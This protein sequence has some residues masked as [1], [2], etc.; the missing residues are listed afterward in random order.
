MRNLPFILFLLCPSLLSRASPVTR[1]IEL[2]ENFQPV[3]KEG[4]ADLYIPLPM[5]ESGYQKV[6][7]ETHESNATWVKEE[8]VVMDK[9]GDSIR[10]LHAHWNKADHPSLQLR[11]VMELTDRDGGLTAHPVDTFFLEPS[12]HVQLDGIVLDTANKITKGLTDPDQ[13]AEAI[14]N[15]IVDNTFRD[16]KTRG[17]GLGDV[18]SLLKSGNFGGK[19]ADLNSLF[20]GLAR[21]SGIPAREIWGLRVSPSTRSPSLGK[22]GDVSKGQHC[23]AE[24]YSNKKKAWFPADAADIRKVIL[25]ENLT[26]N[27]PHVKD[28]RKRFFGT[29]EGNWVALNYGRDF[30][31][32]N[33]KKMNFFMYPQLING[34]FA[35]DGVDPAE[36]SYTYTAKV[37]TQ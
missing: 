8:K 33:G 11:E 12:D 9:I 21:A 15:W 1:Q 16:A 2:L 10:I 18:K 29:W 35:P 24:Y 20:V 30:Q 3:M 37:L 23:R 14:Y 5:K 25:E 26:L 28:L 6:T 31:L 7:S 19:C 36:V 34:S 22:N 17:C 4:V 13:K 27:D 32:S